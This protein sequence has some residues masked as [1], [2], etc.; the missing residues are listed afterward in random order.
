MAQ[1]GTKQAGIGGGHIGV[2]TCGPTDRRGRGR[3]RMK[4]PFMPPLS[5]LP[6]SFTCGTPERAALPACACIH[7]PA[8]WLPRRERT[9]EKLSPLSGCPGS[10]CTSQRAGAG[11]PVR[12]LHAIATSLCFFLRHFVI[13]YLPLLQAFSKLALLIR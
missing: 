7:L 9:R 8:A 4:W 13:Q 2:V 1:S 11:Q 10:D 12:F 6:T 3:A 5:I